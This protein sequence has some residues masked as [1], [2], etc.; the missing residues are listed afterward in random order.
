VKRLEG[1]YSPDAMIDA[2]LLS[3]PL[4]SSREELLESLDPR[5]F[6]DIRTIPG[7]PAPGTVLSSVDDALADCANSKAWLNA[8][9]A[10]LAKYPKDLEAA[11]RSL[12]QGS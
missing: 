9:D 10:A 5:H 12:S 3:A 1:R 7:G 6:I 4:R 2:L 8:R 11:C